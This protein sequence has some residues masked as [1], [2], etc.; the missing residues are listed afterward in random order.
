MSDIGRKGTVPPFEPDYRASGML[1]HVSSND[2]LHEAGQGWWQA[3]PLGP[4]A[5]L[6]AA[7]S[8]PETDC[9]R[10]HA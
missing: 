7:A 9:R 8:R 1:L 4:T 2:Q 10:A 6:L 3:L 5:S